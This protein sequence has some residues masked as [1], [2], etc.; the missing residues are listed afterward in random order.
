MYGFP[1]TLVKWFK[2]YLKERIVFV[3]LG[4]VFSNPATTE[5]DPSIFLLYVNDIHHALMILLKA[6]YIYIMM[7]K[8]FSFF[9]VNL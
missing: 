5:C 6:V 9:K 3:S 4:N 1:E 2:S 8:V 7:T